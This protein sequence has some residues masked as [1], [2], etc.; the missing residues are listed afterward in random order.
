M[1]CERDV[2]FVFA[3]IHISFVSIPT[4]IEHSVCPHQCHIRIFYAICY[5]AFC[6]D[7]NIIH[8]NEDTIYK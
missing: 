6:V 7:T 5:R 4:N 1:V 8:I 3:G 2:L